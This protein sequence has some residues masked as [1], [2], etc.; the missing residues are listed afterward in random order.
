[1]VSVA[2]LVDEKKIRRNP[3]PKDEMPV[4]CGRPRALLF[5]SFL[6]SRLEFWLRL[7][8][9]VVV[10]SYGIVRQLNYQRLEGKVVVVVVIL[11][12]VLVMAIGCQCMAKEGEYCDSS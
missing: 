1:M 6:L 4:A 11:V 7:P 12:L 10:G 5:S 3:E 2:A 8:H 9:M